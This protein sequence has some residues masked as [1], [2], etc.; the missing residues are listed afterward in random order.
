M[1]GS[2]TEAGLQIQSGLQVPTSYP[3]LVFVR[4]EQIA[5][6][7]KKW[8]SVVYP[9]GAIKVDWKRARL[10][11]WPFGERG[12]GHT[13]M[14]LAD[15]A[16]LRVDD[17]PKFTHV[18]LG[19]GLSGARPMVSAKTSYNQFKALA[20]RV[21]R[22]LPERP[23]G[24]GP[25]P[26]V[27]QWAKQFIPDLLPTERV[28]R[29]STEDWLASMPSRRR[30]ALMK[31]YERLKLN[32]WKDSYRYFTAFVKTEL[33]P[34]FQKEGGDL[35]DLKTMLDRLI[36]G[37][38]D[39]THLIAGPWLK[40]LIKMLKHLWDVDA[41]IFYG[42]ADPQKLHQWL[43]KRLVQEK[44]CKARNFRPT[45]TYFWCDFSMYDC[46]HSKDSWDFME[47]WYRLVGIDDEQFWL[48]MKAWI[49]P[50]GSIGP[51]RY[52]APEM[53]ASG[54][55]DTALA[56]AV[57]NGVSTA[58]S[59][60]AAWYNV[61]LRAVT[62]P[63]LLSMR[64]IFAL[65][66]CGDDSLGRLPIVSAERMEQLRSDVVANIA[67]FGFEAKFEMSNDILDAV[68][69]GMRPYPTEKGWFWGKTIGRSTYKMGWT[70]IDRKSDL[71]AHITGVADMHV[72]CSKH[73]PIL[74]DLADKIVELRTGM[75]RTPV[76]LDPDRPWEW[77]FQGGVPYD[78]LT[79]HAVALM[80]TKHNMTVTESDVWG[81]IGE[82]QRVK[83]LPCVVDHWLWRHMVYCDDL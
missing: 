13:D 14:V 38:S 31:A 11:K 48:V 17:P 71:M 72:L 4:G 77:T 20:G 10:P 8:D 2:T 3:G 23:W 26:G 43:N 47:E 46:T 64:A 63:M 56:N 12:K 21:F 29:M 51:F 5:P 27:W 66:V 60:T 16:K 45:S 82:I 59:I 62:R 58:L 68:Y 65:S 36:Q 44:Y 74:A 69:L 80:Y 75:K 22:R 28:E 52:R 73:V 53:N 25:E 50:Q 55:D 1:L 34:G 49:C 42:S 76:K 40:P 24:T 79:I 61:D 39:E 41:M 70:T 9:K 83:R 81:L 35:T 32:G 57:L 18:L 33:L 78:H 30:V 54:R 7:K 37:P 15:L 6:D 67:R 19:I